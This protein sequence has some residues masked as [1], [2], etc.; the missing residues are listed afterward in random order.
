MVVALKV[1][2]DFSR[3]DE[4]L[5]VGTPAQKEAFVRVM[6]RRHITSEPST[7]NIGLRALAASVAAVAIR[8]NGERSRWLKHAGGL[9]DLPAGEHHCPQS[10][11]RGCCR[12]DG[13]ADYSGSA[14]VDWARR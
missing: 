8:V 11:W 10:G 9:I 7:S 4:Q 5:G 12:A 13:A 3:H 2:R 1:E 14:R 6:A